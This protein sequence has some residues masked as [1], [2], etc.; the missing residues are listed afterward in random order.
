MGNNK[1]QLVGHGEDIFHNMTSASLCSSVL[2]SDPD[3]DFDFD[4]DEA[5]SN[6]PG[7]G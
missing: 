5:D 1:L 2:S 4:F 7:G 6:D 3:F